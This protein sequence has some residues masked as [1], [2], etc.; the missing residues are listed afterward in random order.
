ML[1]LIAIAHMP[2]IGLSKGHVLSG[3]VAFLQMKSEDGYVFILIRKDHSFAIYTLNKYVCLND[4][5]VLFFVWLVGRVMS[6]AV[7]AILLI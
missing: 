4:H 2:L 5:F 6:R 1:K 7:P 3:G